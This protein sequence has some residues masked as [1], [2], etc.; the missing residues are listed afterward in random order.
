M[1]VGALGWMRARHGRPLTTVGALAGAA[2][3]VCLGWSAV[4]D[5]R[6]APLGSREAAL[7]A[8][9][10]SPRRAL[11]SSLSL[12]GM[13]T[14]RYYARRSIYVDLK[15]FSPAYAR[16]SL[17][18]DAA[19]R[20]CRPGSGDAAAPR[21]AGHRG[22][23]G[24][25]LCGPQHARA[26]CLA[27][28]PLRGRVFRQPGLPA[29][30]VTVTAT[31]IFDTNGNAISIAGAIGGGTTTAIDGYLGTG[32]LTLSSGTSNYTGINS[33]AAAVAVTAAI[34]LG[35]SSAANAITFPS[36]GT[37]T[38]QIT[39]T[40]FSSS[41]GVTL[42]GPG[43]INI[44]KRKKRYG[45][46]H[47]VITGAGGLTKLGSGTFIVTGTN[48]YTGRT[49]I[50]AGTL[51]VG[52]AGTAGSIPVTTG[53]SITSG[54]TLAYN[55]NVSAGEFAIRTR[56]AAGQLDVH[57]PGRQPGGALYAHGK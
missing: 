41:K 19:R 21:M 6:A 57:Q 33:I 29:T 7:F 37:G 42:T 44:I 12:P 39:G 8:W 38:L 45:I 2:A 15:L 13:D 47:R 53:V 35:S 40:G 46:A 49:T 10:R 52:N 48:N 31:G 55:R 32:T 5:R 3:L 34:N 54:A 1:A 56:S 4:H 36:G 27:A 43:I 24:P 28:A 17:V 20:S 23:L 9:I 26:D 16:G 30:T 22:A 51:Q 14:F 50:S 11:R 25:P 18:A